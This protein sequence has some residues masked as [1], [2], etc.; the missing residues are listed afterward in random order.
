M[1]MDS[2]TK[3]AKQWWVQNYELSL[4]SLVRVLLVILFFSVP[5]LW[6]QSIWTMA[7]FGST[8]FF[9]AAYFLGVLLDQFNMKSKIVLLLGILAISL[10]FL[11]E[12]WYWYVLGLQEFS[13]PLL[14]V[15]MV[16]AFRLPVHVAFG[17]GLLRCYERAV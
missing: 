11:L 9:V 13:F 3:R 12:V 10:S 14:Y 17:Y 15:V 6:K 16:A 4:W 1:E 2:G 5:Y 7:F 8:F